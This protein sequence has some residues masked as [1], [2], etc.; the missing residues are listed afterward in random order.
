MLMIVAP[1]I[2]YLCITDKG[3]FSAETDKEEKKKLD[4]QSSITGD[5]SPQVISGPDVA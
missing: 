2:R 5:E 3:L 4:T 1:F